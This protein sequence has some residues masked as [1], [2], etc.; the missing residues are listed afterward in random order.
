MVFSLDGGFRQE[1]E[2]EDKR[3]KIEE[4]EMKRKEND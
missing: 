1:D 4:R 2:S 3:R